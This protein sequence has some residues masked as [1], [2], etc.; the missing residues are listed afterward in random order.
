MIARELQL[1]GIE[2]AAL[3]E[4]CF[5]AQGQLQE[6]DYTFFRIGKTAGPREAG[7]AFVVHNTIAKRLAS[8]PKAVSP[9]LMSMRVP[10]EKG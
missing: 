8:L 1:F 9:R 6:E 10:I 3:Q 2:I 4:T 5:E 7:V